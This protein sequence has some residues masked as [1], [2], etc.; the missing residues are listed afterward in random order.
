M[1]TFS[2]VSLWCKVEQDLIITDCHNR[3]RCEQ[4]HAE[5]TEA[6]LTGQLLRLENELSTDTITAVKEKDLKY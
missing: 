2:A 1:I 3:T 4:G 5:L 6:G